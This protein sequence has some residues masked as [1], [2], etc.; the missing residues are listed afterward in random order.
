MQ[1]RLG[2]NTADVQ[3]SAAKARVAFGIGVGIGFATGDGEA[4]LRGADGGHVTAG[5]T[6]NNEDIELF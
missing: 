4:E 1:Q 5:A 6:A 2:G 3:A